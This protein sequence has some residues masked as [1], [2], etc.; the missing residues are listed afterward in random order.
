MSYN[1]G[2]NWKKSKMKSSFLIPKFN[3]NSIGSYLHPKKFEDPK[4]IQ[5]SNRILYI[6]SYK[7]LPPKVIKDLDKIIQKRILIENGCYSNSTLVSMEVRG[8]KVVQG[9]YGQ[10]ILK[11][12]NYLKKLNDDSNKGLLNGFLKLLDLS[13]KGKGRFIIYDWGNNQID[14]LD[15]NDNILYTRHCWNKYNGVHF[16]ITCEKQNRLRIMSPWMFYKEIKTFSTENLSDLEINILS[17]KLEVSN[18]MSPGQP[19]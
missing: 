17:N 18:Q 16:D 12:I 1:K 13:K 8:V 14:V 4:F 3:W 15:K 9:W 5:D 11:S 2:K 7:S 10:N 6:P 19:L